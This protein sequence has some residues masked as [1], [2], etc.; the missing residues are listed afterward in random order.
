MLA[1]TAAGAPAIRGAAA[2][3]RPFSGPYVPSGK[4]VA[5]SG[6]RPNPSGFSFPNYSGSASGLTPQTM[7]YLF[8]TSVCR[9]GRGSG[10]IMRPPAQAWMQQT[11]VLL[12]GG[13]CVGFSVDSLLAYAKRPIPGLAAKSTWALRR[14]PQVEQALAYGWTFQFLKNVNAGAVDK[15]PKVVLSKLIRALRTR[16]ELYTLAVFRPDFQGG[17]AVTPF[18]VEKRRDGRYAVLVY[19]NNWPGE[20]RALFVDPASN[21]WSYAASAFPDRPTEVY[22]G[23]L[24]TKTLLLLP[25]LPGLG[26]QPCPFCGQ[27]RRIGGKTLG[28]ATDRITVGSVG[29]RS[30]HLLIV[31]SHGRR[32]GF[33]NGRFVNE[34]PGA[35]IVRYASASHGWDAS[36]DPD[37]LVPQSADLSITVEGDGLKA[38][39]TTSIAR[40][41]QGHDVVVERM[42][43]R[44]GGKNTVRIGAGGTSF[45]FTS[46]GAQSP[47]LQL[48]YSAGQSDHTF[49][50]TTPSLPDGAKVT[51][52]LDP[53]HGRLDIAPTGTPAG[54]AY[55]IETERIDDGGAQTVDTTATGVDS[56]EAVVVDYSAWNAPGEPPP[57][58]SVG[59]A[60]L[61]PD[62]VGTDEGTG[63]RLLEAAG[64]RVDVVDQP[65]TDASLD[66]KVVDQDPPGG[67]NAP[68][69]SFVTIVVG[70]AA[71]QSSIVPDVVGL[72]EQS[73]S[74]ILGRAGFAVARVDRTT[75]NPD[76]NGVVLDQD[77]AGGSEA[78]DGSTVTI[79]VG[80]LS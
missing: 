60:D 9:A 30:P 26:V 25:T 52:S 23:G 18:A 75:S 44:P 48:G 24:K 73:A 19:D 61:V 31:D 39:A 71:G 46:G 36:R 32:L 47:L 66:N 55:G 72:D 58:V 35:S 34:I 37:Y 22:K 7:Q 69:G 5:D 12:T 41:G 59:Q 21:T 57:S 65:V 16:R 6:F 79:G 3:S 54:G 53:A 14:T 17:H 2:P 45:S 1:A 78:P 50:V 27:A 80:R 64:F 11:N 74:A 51:V 38:A 40:I 10:C 29:A 76:E 70:R 20:T 62:V 13:L 28:S 42:R 49:S 63:S 15:S 77:P 33:V 68:A 4:I 43:V 56:G 8:G 67:D